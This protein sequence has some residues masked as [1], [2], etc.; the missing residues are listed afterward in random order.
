MPSTMKQSMLKKITTCLFSVLVLCF[1]FYLV[2][3]EYYDLTDRFVQSS[4]VYLLKGSMIDPD[5]IAVTEEEAQ[6][7]RD[8]VCT[9]K[10]GDYIGITTHMGNVLLQKGDRNY[11]IRIDSLTEATVTG[12]ANRGALFKA[13]TNET[14]LTGK[15]IDVIDKY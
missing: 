6:I 5:K 15:V 13:Y 8:W 2:W 4:E 1:I 10:K 11:Y 14:E 12:R 3:G 9:L 7:I